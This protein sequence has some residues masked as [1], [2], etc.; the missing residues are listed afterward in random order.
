DRRKDEFLAVL[1]HELRNPLAPIRN[2]VQVMKLIGAPGPDWLQERDVIDRQA[3]HLSRLVDDLLD[4]SRIS[5]GK[6]LLRAER[7]DLVPLVRAAVEDHRPLLESAGLSLAA[8]LPDRPIWVQGDPTR[9]SQVAGNL[10][11]NAGKFTDAG[12]SVT[13]RLSTDP[14]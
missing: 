14:A 12:G 2:A 8:E 13:V 4:V 6:V 9:L 1:A 10:L 11:Q 3:A 7:L 5:R